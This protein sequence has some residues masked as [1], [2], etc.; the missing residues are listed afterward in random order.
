MSVLTEFMYY[1]PKNI[2]TIILVTLSQLHR[3]LSV[4]NGMTVDGKNMERNG[5]GLFSAIVKFS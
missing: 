1:L 3:L 2:P 4:A 5:R